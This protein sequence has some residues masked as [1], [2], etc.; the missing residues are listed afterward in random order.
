[1]GVLPE[2]VAMT[3][4]RSSVNASVPYVQISRPPDKVL[5]LFGR[6]SCEHRN[7]LSSLFVAP[8][9]TRISRVCLAV[10]SPRHATDVA[11][12]PPH[13]ERSV[14]A[15]NPLA[16][17][18][19]TSRPYRQPRLLVVGPARPREDACLRQAQAVTHGTAPS[20]PPS[21][22]GVGWS[23]P[24]CAACLDRLCTRR[25]Q[26][27]GLGLALERERGAWLPVTEGL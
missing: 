9:R 2:R 8:N 6:P 3:R 12:E 16:R 4:P 20:H 25:E 13:A 23:R 10:G 19:R 1:M 27:D 7:R 11:V 22:S 21:D 15:V 5:T 18:S 26:R 24:P 17:T 14:S